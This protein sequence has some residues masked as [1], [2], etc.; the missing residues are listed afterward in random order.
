MN[1]AKCI[2]IILFALIPLTSSAGAWTVSVEP[3]NVPLGSKSAPLSTKIVHQNIENIDFNIPNLKHFE[4]TLIKNPHPQ[5][6]FRKLVCN[7]K[8]TPQHQ[9]GVMATCEGGNFLQ[10]MTT[11]KNRDIGYTITVSCI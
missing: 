7:K 4:C 1:Y 5:N 10:I 11:H 3:F 6:H 8:E 9:F 2:F